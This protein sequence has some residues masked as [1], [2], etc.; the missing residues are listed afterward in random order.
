MAPRMLAYGC[1]L[2]IGVRDL[3]DIDLSRHQ[4]HETATIV[5]P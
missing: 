3:L 1:K 5:A 4:K 2:Q